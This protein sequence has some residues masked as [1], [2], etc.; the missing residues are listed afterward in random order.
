MYIDVVTHPIEF[1]QYKVVA[2]Y[3]LPYMFVAI[4]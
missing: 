2:S 1:H 4:V 3:Y